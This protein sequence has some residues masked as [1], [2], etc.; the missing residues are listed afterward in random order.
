LHKN[1]ATDE[2]DIGRFRVGLSE[3]SAGGLEFT[4]A[5]SRLLLRSLPIIGYL[6][7]QNVAINEKAARKQYEEY[8]R[9]HPTESK[10]DFTFEDF[11]RLRVSKLRALAYEMQAIVSFFLAAMIAKAFVPDDPEEDY[12]G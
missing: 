2:Y 3:L 4:K 12:T 11:C 6:A 5:F 1:L 7:N 10:L 8:F 9:E